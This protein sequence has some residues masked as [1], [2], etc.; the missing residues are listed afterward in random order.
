MSDGNSPN[1]EWL[2]RVSAANCPAVGCE[3]LA[4]KLLAATAARDPRAEALAEALADVVLGAEPLRLARAVLA[5]GAHMLDRALGLGAR[6][7]PSERPGPGAAPKT[8]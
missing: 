5:G 4:A 2:Q 1:L 8:P 3:A 7:L 6:G